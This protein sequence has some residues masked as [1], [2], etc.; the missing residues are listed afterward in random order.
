MCILYSVYT[1]LLQSSQQITLY[2]A[3]SK[4]KPSI[5]ILSNMTLPRDSQKVV[6]TV[7]AMYNQSITSFSGFHE[8]N[9]INWMIGP[10]TY[11][12]HTRTIQ[13]A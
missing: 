13:Y 10:G 8:G 4:M 1:Y 12:I 2:R 3:G 5:Q 11:T 7:Q 9:K 6:A